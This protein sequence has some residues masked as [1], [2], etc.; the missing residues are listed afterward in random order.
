MLALLQVGGHPPKLEAEVIEP[1]R[2]LDGDYVF[3]TY[4]VPDRKLVF[5]ASAFS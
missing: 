4:L 3:E 2:A 1:I 5:R